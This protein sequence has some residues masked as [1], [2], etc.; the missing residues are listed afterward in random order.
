MKHFAILCT[1]VT[2]LL[3]VPVQAA[4]TCDT[5]NVVNV[6]VNGLVCDFCA[7]A[8]EKVFGAR[9]EVEE[10]GVDLDNGLVHVTLKPGQTMEDEALTKLITDSG[11]NVTAI[12]KAC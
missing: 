3:T 8:L 6:K 1:L 2:L 5:G 11:Y 4:E 10:I 9:E 12:E 7:R